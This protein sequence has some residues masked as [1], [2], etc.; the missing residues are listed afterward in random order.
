MCVRSCAAVLFCIFAP[1]VVA[2]FGTQARPSMRSI[3]R[4]FF[5]I[6]IVT[7][8]VVPSPSLSLLVCRG[9]IAKRCCLGAAVFV[10]TAARAFVVAVAGALAG[11]FVV[12]AIATSLLVQQLQLPALS[13]APGVVASGFL[14]RLG[15]LSPKLRRRFGA[16]V[17]GVDGVAFVAAAASVLAIAI[18]SGYAVGARGALGGGV[19]IEATGVWGPRPF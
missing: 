5:Q 7:S 1:T 10:A 3:L 15:P 8:R 2:V 16:L 13:S 19:A 9:R 4:G 14:P 18:A 11:E 6:I 12:V 17:L